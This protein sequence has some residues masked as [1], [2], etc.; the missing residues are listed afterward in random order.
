MKEKKW[1]KENERKKIKGA[2]VELVW[3]IWMI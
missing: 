2:L 1:E 3:S